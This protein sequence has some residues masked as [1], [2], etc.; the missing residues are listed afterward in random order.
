MD[1]VLMDEVVLDQ[2]EATDEV[3]AETPDQQEAEAVESTGEKQEQEAAPDVSATPVETPE[4]RRAKGQEAAIVAERRR[5]QELEQELQQLRSQLPKQETRTSDF[6]QREQFQSDEH[7]FQAV[8]EHQ[9][10]QRFQEKLSQHEAQQQQKAEQEQLLAAQ[11][12]A[13]QRVEKGR[14]KYPDFDAVVNEG[15][16]PFLTPSL[17]QL[18]IT[19]D[20]GEDLAHF[21]GTTPSEAARIADMPER[22]MIREVTLLEVKLK[23]E[24]SKPAPTIPQTLTQARNAAG[25]FEQPQSEPTPLDA[26]LARSK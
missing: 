10:E 25:R 11:K 1:D 6:P 7:F 15:L 4:Q 14:A 5:R 13:D 23:S 22:Q 20:V 3:V 17:H 24:A 8:I 12:V 21:L 18:I 9:A 16:A 26:I 19:S 2:P